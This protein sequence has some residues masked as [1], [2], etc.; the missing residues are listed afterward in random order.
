M[1]SQELVRQANSAIARLQFPAGMEEFIDGPKWV[2]SILLGEKYIEP[3]PEFILRKLALQT[4]LGESV[5]EVFERGG[6]LKVQEMVPDTANGET[7][8]FEITDL[9]VSASDYKTG[10]P[11]YVIIEAFWLDSGQEFK[12]ST[13]A[14]NIQA[15]LIGL[16]INKAWPIR[17]KF[18]RGDMKDKGDRYLLFLMPPD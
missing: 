15:I 14:T 5:E 17:A 16:L 13:G 8:P 10:N 11:C 2:K 18:K 1:P 4:I 12:C 7:E 6:I 9:Y 3:D